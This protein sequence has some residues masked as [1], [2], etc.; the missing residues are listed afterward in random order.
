M[1]RDAHVLTPLGEGILDRR[2]CGNAATHHEDKS[3]YKKGKA[4]HLHAATAKRRYLEV[5]RCAVATAWSFGVHDLRVN[6]GVF[7]SDAGG[8]DQKLLWI[9]T[10]RAL[11]PG[12]PADHPK[13]FA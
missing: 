4:S 6:T 12:F 10:T 9:A 11:A 1:L 13:L 2:P 7:E 8:V 3:L 5:L